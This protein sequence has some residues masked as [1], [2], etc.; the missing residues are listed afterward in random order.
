LL[1]LD[2]GR[3][4]EAVAT[5]ETAV[6]VDRQ[7]A[8]TRVQLGRAYLASRAPDKAIEAFETATASTP[9]NPFILNEAAWWLAEHA[10][11]L[12]RARTYAERGIAAASG[13]VG[14]MP[15]AE[16]RRWQLSPLASLVRTWDTLGWIAFK[17]GDLPTA[18]TWLEAAYVFSDGAEVAWHVGLLR[19]REG[20]RQAALEAYGRAASARQ[21]PKAEAMSAV[22]RLER[23]GLSL[24]GGLAAAD[25]K[26]RHTS[27]RV[28]P[29]TS[30]QRGEIIVSLDITGRVSEVETVSGEVPAAL[31]A[32]LKVVTIP[33]SDVAKAR[34]VRLFR[35][36]SVECQ[37][38]GQCTLIWHRLP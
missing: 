1:L 10:V 35:T 36:G 37:V 27:V 24:P 19:E 9:P 11:D 31:P 25:L 30:L 16:M 12:P 3:L 34:Q 18:R 14:A 29:Q 2:A 33:G 28:P 26:Q 21:T 5:L 13:S 38:G 23:Q 8:F 22:T 6:S 4:E 20:R 15:L 17:E 7:D 32:A